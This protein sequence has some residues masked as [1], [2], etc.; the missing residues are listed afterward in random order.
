MTDEARSRWNA[1]HWVATGCVLIA[2]AVW[3]P[4]RPAHHTSDAWR[5]VPSELE[6]QFVW[7]LDDPGVPQALPGIS[8]G[9]PSVRLV[10]GCVHWPLFLVQHLIF[11]NV[12]GLLGWILRRRGRRVAAVS[13]C[14]AVAF[15]FGAP[16]RA[17]RRWPEAVTPERAGKGGKRGQ[18]TNLG[19]ARPLARREFAGTRST[20][21]N[22]YRTVL[23][24]EESTP[25]R[26]RANASRDKSKH[27]AVDKGAMPG[28]AAP[29]R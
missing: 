2:L 17:D 13:G 27:P 3:V 14:L 4:A 7:R 16:P 15:V 25:R 20:G 5:L 9:E 23:A 8:V 6:W 12:A 29:G 21:T 18:A 11:L 26:N 28:R 10:P 22:R 24:R 19:G 1:V